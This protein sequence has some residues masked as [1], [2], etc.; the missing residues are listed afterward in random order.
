ML[1]IIKKVK[2][3]VKNIYNVYMNCRYEMFCG[4]CGMQDY[5]SVNYCKKYG[6]IFNKG[7]FYY[8]LLLYEFVLVV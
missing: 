3:N 5:I 1:V 7:I 4:L 2:E 8:L 6:V